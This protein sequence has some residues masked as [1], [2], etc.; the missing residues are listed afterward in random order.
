MALQVTTAE[1]QQAWA[2]AMRFCALWQEA[3]VRTDTVSSSA[4]TFPDK[5]AAFSYFQANPAVGG[6]F[7]IA[8][9]INA[10][11]LAKDGAQP[12]NK[13]RALYHVPHSLDPRQF[14]G[15][16]NSGKIEA[17]VGL[18]VQVNSWETL[19]GWFT[20]SELVHFGWRKDRIPVLA[21]DADQLWEND[22]RAFAYYSDRHRE[23][24][25]EVA[26]LTEA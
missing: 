26:V 13:R 25:P 22:P 3:I 20:E 10:W 23:P 1:D 16:M 4:F 24:P 5:K 11:L 17:E 21:M 12:R 15:S 9:A 8:V 2:K 18:F 14:L 7:T 6:F 19:R